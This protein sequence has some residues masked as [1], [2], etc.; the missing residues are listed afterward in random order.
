MPRIFVYGTLKRGGSN[1]SCLEGQR[2][3]GE[4][5]TEPS[6]RLYDL[7]GYPGMVPAP[8]NG[9]SIEGELWEIDSSCLAR[10]DD[11]EDTAAGLYSRVAIRLL[12]PHDSREAETYVYRRS[13][14]GRPDLGT[15]FSV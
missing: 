11:L 5:G 6:F 4:A 1:H 15:R 2:F 9:L 3:A 8:E 14:A 10:L 12:P 7:G 13:V